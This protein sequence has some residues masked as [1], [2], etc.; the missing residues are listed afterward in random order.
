MA[1]RPALTNM[2][3]PRR[4]WVGPAPA[5]ASFCARAMSRALRT[6]ASPSHA[7]SGG[8]AALFAAA[9]ASSIAW[10][11]RGVPLHRPVRRH[12]GTRQ[13][14]GNPHCSALNRSMRS[15]RVTA[16]GRPPKLA[17]LSAPLTIRSPVPVLRPSIFALAAAG[18]RGHDSDGSAGAEG[19]PGAGP[20]GSTPRP[21]RWSDP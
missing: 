14:G 9:A 6:S 15:P 12:R 4:G 18:A 3:R 7:W 21:D 5:F 20:V 8:E 16:R 13:V 10:Q 2:S 1:L 19:S 11:A 17:L